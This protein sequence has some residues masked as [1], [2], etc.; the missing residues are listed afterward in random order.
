M[1]SQGIAFVALRKRSLY[2]SQLLTQQDSPLYRDVFLRDALRTTRVGAL[3]TRRHAVVSFRMN[4]RAEEMLRIFHQEADQE[5]FPVVSDEG[6]LLGVVNARTTRLLATE[7]DDASWALA[8]D[9]MLPPIALHESDDLR[10]ASKQF[11][12]NGLRELPVVDDAGRVIGFLDETCACRGLPERRG[13]R[14]RG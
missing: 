9:V 1:L 10:F 12:E 2:V 13:A 14:G 8:A 5:A 7:A 11:L 6:T 3:M 4:T